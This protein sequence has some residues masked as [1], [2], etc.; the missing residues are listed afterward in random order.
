[1]FIMFTLLILPIIRRFGV[2]VMNMMNVFDTIFD[3]TLAANGS[4]DLTNANING[5]IYEKNELG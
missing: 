3:G 5:D 4:P 1:M 2:N